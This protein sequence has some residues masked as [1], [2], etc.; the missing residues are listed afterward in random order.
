M[1]NLVHSFYIR[2]SLHPLTISTQ[3]VHPSSCEIINRVSIEKESLLYGKIYLS[4]LWSSSWTNTPRWESI[5]SISNRNCKSFM[6]V[7]LLYQK[8][9]SFLLSF[10]GWKKNTV[11]GCMLS[12]LTF[13]VRPKTEIFW[14]SRILLPNFYT[15]HTSG[16]QLMLKRQLYLTQLMAAES[17]KSCVQGV[18]SVKKKGTRKIIVGKNTIKNALREWSTKT[19]SIILLSIKQLRM[20]RVSQKGKR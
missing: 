1:P 6:R 17:V 14:L 3:V 11:N 10:M 18:Y 7:R 8:T 13:K 4:I 2:W 16:L 9:F 19:L 5:S 15:N 20:M 12:A